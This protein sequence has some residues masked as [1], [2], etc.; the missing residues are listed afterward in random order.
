MYS[1]LANEILKLKMHI[2]LIHSYLRL[3][4]TLI[5]TLYKEYFCGVIMI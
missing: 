5:D 1:K 4:L 2:D 3:Y